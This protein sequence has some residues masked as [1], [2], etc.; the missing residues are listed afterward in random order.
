MEDEAIFNSYQ[1][2]IGL[3]DWIANFENMYKAIQLIGKSLQNYSTVSNKPGAINN[4][5]RINILI[6]QNNSGKSRFLRTLFNDKK[7]RYSSTDINLEKH[8][9]VLKEIRSALK[10]VYTKRRVE[11][12][13]EFSSD[14]MTDIQFMHSDSSIWQT[15]SRLQELTNGRSGY[16]VKMSRGLMMSDQTYLRNDIKT[17][18]HSLTND[19][20]EFTKEDIANSLRRTIYI[21]TLRGLRR[22]IVNSDNDIFRDF[23]F[24]RTARDYFDINKIPP[25]TIYTGLGLYDDVRKLL[26]GPT[27]GRRKIRQFEVFLSK[28]FFEGQDVNIIPNIEDTV[29]H[30]KIGEEEYPIYELGDGIQAIIILTYPLFFRQGEPLNI[31]IEEP[32]L[33]LHPGFQRIF[34][35]TL[36]RPEFQSFQ[37]FF[38]THSNHFLDM[39]LDFKDISVYCFTKVDKDKFE[40]ENVSNADDRVLEEIGVRNSSVFLSNCTIWVEGI[41]DRIYLRRYLDLY[42]KSNKNTI[43]VLEDVHYSFVEYSGGNITHWSFLDDDDEEHPNINVERL[44]G[45]I[46]LIADRDK[47]D[48]SNSG[49]DKK[50]LRIKKLQEVLGERFY[51]I[52]RREIENLLTENMRLETVRKL[53]KPDTE[54]E[55]VSVKGISVDKTPIGTWIHKKVSGINRTYEAKSG[56]VKDKVVFAKTAVSCINSFDDMSDEA[57]E[58]SEMIY[59]FILNQNK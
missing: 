47:T 7:L 35:Q 54:L 52:K 49:K 28:S 53:E 26:L 16:Q 59:N 10:E 46:F 9:S 57:K 27:K 30:V 19:L 39:T 48:L 43:P 6:G 14:I 13:K 17:S 15:K 55:L 44:C 18:A 8:N 24:E 56:T 42:Q 23:Y 58:L 11:D 38:T 20:P 21:P 5:S 51:C 1:H 36:S 25:E 33:F 45:K 29:V 40:I 37:F 4:L 31:C 34:L 22:L 3:Q 32:D 41:T 2:C 12:I 50:S